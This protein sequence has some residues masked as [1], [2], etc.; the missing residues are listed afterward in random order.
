MNSHSLAH[1]KQVPRGQAFFGRKKQQVSL[2]PATSPGNHSLFSGR[3]GTPVHHIPQCG[4]RR[5][6]LL[7][8]LL[9]GHEVRGRPRLTHTFSKGTLPLKSSLCPQ[10][11]PLTVVYALDLDKG[12][13]S[14]RTS[15]LSLLRLP[16]M[17]S[18]S[19]SQ[20]GRTLKSLE[21]F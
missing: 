5:P 4:P 20:P 18:N 19:G 15:L 12:P 1:E 21:V 13:K 2:C 16:H 14:H 8:G 3:H 11:G 9:S 17:A 6:S 7:R 10:P